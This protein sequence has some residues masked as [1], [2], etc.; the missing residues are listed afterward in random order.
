MEGD[1]ERSGGEDSTAVRWGGLRCGPTGH[2]CFPQ[3]AS[4]PEG[5]GRRGWGEGSYSSQIYR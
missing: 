3:T 1:C 4:P 5:G 2:H